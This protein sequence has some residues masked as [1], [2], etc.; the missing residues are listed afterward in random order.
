[1]HIW[2]LVVAIRQAQ[3]TAITFPTSTLPSRTSFAPN[4]K[5]WTNMPIAIN[6][7]KPEVIAH[8]R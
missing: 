8:T 3:K 6:W 1:M 5:P 2:K 4:Q 7:L